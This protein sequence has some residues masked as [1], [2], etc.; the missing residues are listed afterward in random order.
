MSTLSEIKPATVLVLGATGKTGRRVTSLLGPAARPASRS[1]ATKFDWSTQDTWEPALVGT[2]AVYVVPP[3]NPA[4]LAEFVPLAVKSGVTR[5]VLLSMRGAPED[6]PFEAAIK[7]SG[8]EWT[9]LRP[10]WFMQNFD[11][12]LFAEPVRH[13]ELAVPAGQGVH[14]FIDV[15]DI[16]E[17][18]V[19]ALTQPE[20]GNNH[21]A[22][23][24]ELSGSESLSFAEMLARIVEVTGNPIL[25]T[26]VEPDEF[27]AS[28][29]GLGYPDEI[30]DLVTML[31]VRIRTGEEA[32]LSDG[33]QR[34]LGRAPR[35]FADYLGSSSFV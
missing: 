31:L 26:D 30:A 6:D 5:L 28:L 33:V 25:Y 9:I 3:D 15:L 19:A 32:H 24:Y 20:G 21:A 35:T 11:E 1:S 14:P 12:D 10:T 16:A 18:A 22:Q 34:V 23:T 13:G 2:T 4:T 17:V 29:R 27:A 8:V 7:D